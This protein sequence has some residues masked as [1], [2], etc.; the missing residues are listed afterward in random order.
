M[1]RITAHRPPPGHRSW[2][3]RVIA[4]LPET[5]NGVSM[6]SRVV[7]IELSEPLPTLMPNGF[8]TAHVLVMLH[9]QPLGTI[10]V[11]LNQGPVRPRCL[12]ALARSELGEALE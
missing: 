7:D 1:W 2:L 11:K 12:M 9:A 3:R 4:K 8:A 6:P 10:E 5:R